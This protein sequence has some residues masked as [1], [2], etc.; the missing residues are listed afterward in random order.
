VNILIVGGEK[1]VYFLARLFSS[2]GHSVIVINRDRRECARLARRLKST[3]VH[4]DGS[5]LTILQEAGARNADA[6]L[7][8]T[9]ND[10]D[11]LVICQLASFHFGVPRTLALVNDPD[12]EEVFQ[13]LQITSA[14]SIT[15]L[16]A[17]LIEQ[18]TGFDDIINLVPVGEGKLNLTEIL[19][20]DT[21]PV[22]GRTLQE[23][24]LPENS[25]VASIMRTGEPIIPRGPTVLAAGDQLIVITLPGNHGQV[26]KKLTGKTI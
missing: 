5:D 19:L 13:K 22:V 2:K 17:S 26:L 3:I 8:A 1:L 4:G 25:L 12:N 21:S 11:N 24:A 18:R 23:V 6:V 10:E 7:A 20:K 15:R 9:P 14:L 16:L